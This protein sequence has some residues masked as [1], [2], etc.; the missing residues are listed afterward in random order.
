MQSTGGVTNE[1][2]DQLNKVYAELDTLVN[3]IGLEYDVDD[4][5]ICR[6]TDQVD[7]VWCDEEMLESLENAHSDLGY[8][9]GKHRS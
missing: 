6:N 5:Y 3:L 8:F 1:V 9:L 2:W 4:G 7:E